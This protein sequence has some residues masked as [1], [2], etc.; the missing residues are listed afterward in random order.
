[1]HAHCDHIG[2][3][4]FMGNLLSV[5]RVGYDGR[6]HIC[7][8]CGWSTPN[9]TALRVHLAYQCRIQSDGRWKRGSRTVTLSAQPAGQQS[10]HDHHHE[11]CSGCEDQEP[12]QWDDEDLLAAINEQLQQLQEETGEQLCTEATAALADLLVGIMGNGKKFG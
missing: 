8:R 7:S 5:N 2:I 10:S 9:R 4:A 11:G 6:I 3:L 1:M 12:G